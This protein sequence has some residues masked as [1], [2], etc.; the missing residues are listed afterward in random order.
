MYALSSARPAALA[1]YAVGGVYASAR[2]EAEA[3][4]VEAAVDA[5]LARCTEERVRGVDGLLPRG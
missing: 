2:L 1:R 3:R 4:R 5:L